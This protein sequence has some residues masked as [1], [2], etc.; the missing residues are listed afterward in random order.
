MLLNRRHQ[1]M[2]NWTKNWLVL[3]DHWWTGD[4]SRHATTNFA[5]ASTVA[6]LNEVK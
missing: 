3:L 4:L 6:G 5:W 1:W 2:M